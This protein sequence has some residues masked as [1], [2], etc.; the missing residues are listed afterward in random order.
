MNGAAALQ[1]SISDLMKL[2]RE[3]EERLQMAELMQLAESSFQEWNDPEENV[4]NAQP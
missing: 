3:I 2:F 1:L 4:C